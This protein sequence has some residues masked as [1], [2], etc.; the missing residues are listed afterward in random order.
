MRYL[1]ITVL[2]TLFVFGCSKNI[3]EM[4]HD[5]PALSVICVLSTHLGFQQAYVYDTTTNTA[6]R[7]HASELFNLDA[8]ITIR[9]QNQDIHFQV[10]NNYRGHPIYTDSPQKLPIVH[11]QSYELTVKSGE[12]TITGQTT[13]PGDFEIMTP[14]EEETF[15]LSAEIALS[16]T[17]SEAAFG[18]LI[19]FSGPPMELPITQDSTIIFRQRY[20]FMAR[21]TSL[22][23]TG[24]SFYETGEYLL[25][26]L[27]FDEN[28]HNHKFEGLD[29]SGIEGGYGLFGASVL[30]SRCIFIVE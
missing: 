23:I 13:I 4:N 28:Y 26:I 15:P 30:K 2:T 17:Q 16:W 3:S 19:E 7:P 24:G 1:I 12:T 29:V 25:R 10:Q 8:Q 27:A 20:N 5:F 22:V 11:G 14:K 18:Y 6:D 21:D 9:Y